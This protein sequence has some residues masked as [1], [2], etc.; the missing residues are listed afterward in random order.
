MLAQ[1][2]R[3]AIFTQLALG[4]ALAYWLHANGTLSMLGAVVVTSALPFVVLI[5]V[6]IY[7]A[8]ISRGPEP[9]GK[10][11]TSLLGECRASIVIFLL[12][13]P[14]T[15]K[16]P[17]L[18][19]ATCDQQRIPVVLVHGYL[20]NHRIWDDVAPKLRAQGHAVFAVNLEPLFCSIDTYAAVVESAVQTLLAQSQHERVALVGHSMGGLA[21]RAWLRVHG[22]DRAARVLTL[23]TPHVGTQIPQHIK[24][25]NG[26]QM[27]WKSGWLDTLTACETPATHRLLRIAL[28]PQDNIV[29]PQRAQVLPN[30]TPTVFEGI[31]HLQMCLDP[32]VSQWLK[33]QL[34]E[35][36]VVSVA[37]A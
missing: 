28:S 15:N 29:Y 30:M 17:E 3:H 35:V 10:W 19:Q 25:K 4:A 12:H 36:D 23:G 9:W 21:I 6:N 2:L 13:Q 5:L 31:G 26:N 27:T 24:S 1:L 11:L 8:V 37:A 32:A 34:A 22:S 20:C 18:L 7:T 33:D 14:W 16:Q